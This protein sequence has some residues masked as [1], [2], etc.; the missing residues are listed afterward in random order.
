MSYRDAVVDQLFQAVDAYVNMIFHELGCDLHIALRC[1]DPLRHHG[2]IAD[3]QQGSC[4]DLIKKSD[5][6]D[7]GCLHVDG[8]GPY[9]FQIFLK[10]LVVLPYS[11]VSRIDRA[12]PIVYGV[13]ADSGGDGLLEGECRE[14]GTSGGK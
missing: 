2:L 7:G 5:R 6:E 14:A 9:L 12:C 10:R 11:S 3:E 13:F 8:V 1:L 4:G